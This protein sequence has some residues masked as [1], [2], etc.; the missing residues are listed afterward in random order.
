[1]DALEFPTFKVELIPSNQDALGD[2]PFFIE[3]CPERGKK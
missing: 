1:L 2:V 3:K